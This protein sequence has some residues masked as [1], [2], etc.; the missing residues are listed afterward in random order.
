MTK[1][2]QMLS[3]WARQ[4]IRTQKEGTLELDDVTVTIDR[5]GESP[6]PLAP[7]QRIDFPELAE[8]EDRERAK[9]I[10]FGLY[11]R[12]GEPTHAGCAGLWAFDTTEEAIELIQAV[13]RGVLRNAE[14]GKPVETE[15]TFSLEG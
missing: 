10:H 3:L 11:I 4:A 6:I 8:F 15:N 5:F 2:E 9:P 7:E 14:D 12:A 13:Y 1:N